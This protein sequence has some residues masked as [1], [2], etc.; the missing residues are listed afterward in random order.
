MPSFAI[1]L[2]LVSTVG[3]AGW[4][5]LAKGRTA[6]AAFFNRM[7]QIIT[8]AGAAPAIW[9]QVRSS[10]LDGVTLGYAVLSGFF[11]G[12]YYLFLM[13]G[14]S[15]SDFTVVYPV[16]RALPV[17]VLGV[18][19]VILGRTPT[20]GGWIGMVLVVGGCVLAPQVRFR[21]MSVRAYH[22]RGIVFMVCTALGTVGYTLVDKLAAERLVSGGSAAAALYGYVFFAVSWPTYHLFRRFFGKGNSSGPRGP[23]PGARGWRLAIVGA[24]LNFGSYWLILWAYQQCTRA[25]YV[26]AFRQFSIVIGVAAALFLY[27]EPGRWVRL[28]AAL[29]VTLGLILVGLAG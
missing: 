3:H 26:V 9:W 15:S 20:A 5:L 29:L 7:L 4:N 25:S 27:R 6:K 13:L 11:C 17:L 14:Y 21:G 2:I 28:T 8:I 10:Q 16:A 1:F 24:V 12:F 23:K 19:D 18:A 22:G